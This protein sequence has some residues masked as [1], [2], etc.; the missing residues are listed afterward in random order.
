MRIHMGG[1]GQ[2]RRG[3]L[4]IGST[5][6]TETVACLILAYDVRRWL[7]VQSIE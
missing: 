1:R 5:D 4:L 6:H 3:K 7:Q 2:T